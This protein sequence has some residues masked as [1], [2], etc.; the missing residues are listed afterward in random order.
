MIVNQRSALVEYIARKSLVCLI[1]TF[2]V[3]LVMNLLKI[4]SF[5]GDR[6]DVSFKFIFLYFCGLL[7]AIVSY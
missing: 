7:L 2:L 4:T 1:L 3:N 5:I 6:S